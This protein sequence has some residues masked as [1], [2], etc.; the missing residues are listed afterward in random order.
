MDALAYIL[1][2]TSQ[3]PVEAAVVAALLGFGFN[4]TMR[5]LE[6]LANMTRNV[7]CSIKDAVG[8]VKR[9]RGGKK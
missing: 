5:G 3:D 6:T 7:V 4:Q 1:A 2:L 8:H 9:L